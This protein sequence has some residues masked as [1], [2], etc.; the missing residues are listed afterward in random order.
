MLERIW[1]ST[2]C[3]SASTISEYSITYPGIV[4]LGTCCPQLIAPYAVGLF[5]AS[6]ME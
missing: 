5:C 6:R 1:E 2:R 3:P 4:L